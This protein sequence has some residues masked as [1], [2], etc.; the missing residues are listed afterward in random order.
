M[1]TQVFDDVE[2]DILQL[3]N[4]SPDRHAFTDEIGVMFD[5]RS[6]MDAEILLFL[7][8]EAVDNACK[9]TGEHIKGGIYDQMFRN[10]DL[11]VTREQKVKK[12]LHRALS[13]NKSV[14]LEEDSY[15]KVCCRL[16]G[17]SHAGLQKH[18]QAVHKVDVQAY[19]TAFP[20]APVMSDALVA[21][22]KN[23]SA[24]HA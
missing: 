19:L 6:E 21:N 10:L 15:E 17:Q 4:P 5:G 1:K 22:Y 9:G 11:V 16:C 3:R 2:T 20:G 8:D 12:A 13:A 23:R 24:T 18:L 7:T 14:T